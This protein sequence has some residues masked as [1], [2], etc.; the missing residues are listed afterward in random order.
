MEDALFSILNGISEYRLSDST[1][2]LKDKH[3][4]KQ[5]LQLREQVRLKPYEWSAAK[6]AKSSYLTDSHFNKV[7]YRLFGVTPGEDVKNFLIEYA[8]KLLLETN[9][10]IGEI[11]EQCGYRN[12]ENFIRI[13][14][15][16]KGI[17]PS[18]Y[19]KRL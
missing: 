19:R 17:T 14:K 10:S 16:K 4:K 7:Y 12:T 5:F 15:Q 13:F 18:K 1:R 11:A 6:M 2:D 3:M 9:I 8:E